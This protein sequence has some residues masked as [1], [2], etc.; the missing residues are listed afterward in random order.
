MTRVKLTDFE[1]QE[2][3]LGRT[4]LSMDIWQG[5]T[6]RGSF[7]SAHGFVDVF[8]SRNPRWR[9]TAIEYLHEGVS[10]S[11]RWKALFGDRTIARLAREL[12]EDVIAAP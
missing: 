2:W 5:D 3:A 6:R 8:T 12:V 10:Y 7:R 9:V 4:W 1:Q 11:R